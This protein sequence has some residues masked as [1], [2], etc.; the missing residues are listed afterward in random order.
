MFYQTALR[1]HGLPHDPFKA[2]VVPRPIGWISSLDAEGRPN[3]APY[4]FFNAVAFDPPVV[5]FG[6]TMRP[7]QSARKDSHANI[8]ATGEFVVNLA[9]EALRE[10]MNATAASLPPGGDEFAHAGLATLPSRMV[11]PPR[12]AASPVALECRYLRTVELPCD[13]PGR[14]NYAVFGRVVG[15]HIDEA[16]IVD[17]RVDILRCR[18]LARLGYMDYTVVDNIFAMDRPG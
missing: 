9:T 14:T 17:G 15:I 4:S 12:V 6:S 10:A 5:V 11:K 7:R 16:L 18:P 2:L 1:D 3:L 13:A 8:E